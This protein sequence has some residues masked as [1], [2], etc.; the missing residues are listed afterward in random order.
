MHVQMWLELMFQGS[1]SDQAHIPTFLTMF[2]THPTART[3]DISTCP[4]SAVWMVLQHDAIFCS[5]N[6]APSFWHRMMFSVGPHLSL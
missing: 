5:Y 4:L 6:T 2:A 3:Q 1:K